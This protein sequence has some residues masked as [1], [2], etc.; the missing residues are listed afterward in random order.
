MVAKDTGPQGRTESCGDGHLTMY[1]SRLRKQMLFCAE[2]FDLLACKPIK[3][4]TRNGNG[5]L[6]DAGKA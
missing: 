6:N 2:W 5:R 4:Q 1:A 3:S